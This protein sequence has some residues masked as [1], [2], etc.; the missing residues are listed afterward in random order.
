LALPQITRD[1]VPIEAVAPVAAVHL[2][3]CRATTTNTA[4]ES[5]ERN[6]QRLPDAA[7]RQ[8]QPRPAPARRGAAQFET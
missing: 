2:P 1:A 5:D 7:E 6:R 3:L 4:G 8:R